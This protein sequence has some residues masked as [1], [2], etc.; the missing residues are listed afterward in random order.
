MKFPYKHIMY[1][2]QIHSS[3]TLSHLP[4]HFSNNFYSVALFYLSYFLQEDFD[5]TLFAIII[6]SIKSSDKV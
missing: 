5:I 6:I 3:I 1:F 2:C 4:P